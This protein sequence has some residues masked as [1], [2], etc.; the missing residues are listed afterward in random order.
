MLDGAEVARELAAQ[1]ERVEKMLE[2]M[3]QLS[4][5]AETGEPLLSRRLYEGVRGAQAGGL[6]E[7]LEEAQR[8]SQYGSRS[9]A[10]Q[11]ERDAAKSIDAL[12]ESVEKAADSVLGSEADALRVARAELDQLIEQT[13]QEIATTGEEQGDKSSK[14][15]EGLHCPRL[16]HCRSWAHHHM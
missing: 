11:A 16:H 10:Q 14:D 12:A 5:D 2:S 13:Q 7:R 6:E 3:K 4:E 8:Q 9:R 1:R 15:R